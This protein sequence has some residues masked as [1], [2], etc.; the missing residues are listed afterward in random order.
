MVVGVDAVAEAALEAGCG[1]RAETKLL[2]AEERLSTEFEG[3]GIGSRTETV[4]L[5]ALEAGL[6]ASVAEED[7]TLAVSEFGGVVVLDPER[8]ETKLLA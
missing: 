8:V 7:T 4:A 5:V 2:T 6:G 1:E 3:M